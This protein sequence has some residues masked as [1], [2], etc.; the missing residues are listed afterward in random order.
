MANFI[1][2]YTDTGTGSGSTKPYPNTGADFK[3]V[4]VKPVSNI[5]SKTTT[6]KTTTTTTTK[7]TNPTTTQQVA[8]PTPV[9]SSGGGESSGGGGGGGGYEQPQYNYNNWNKYLE[10]MNSLINNQFNLEKDT[11]NKY[12]S[13]AGTNLQRTED[14]WNSAYNTNRAYLDQLANQNA[15]REQAINAAISD[16]Y[17][18]LIGNADEYYQNLIGTY[19]RSMGYVNQ[20]YEEGRSASEQARDEAINLAQ[21]LY[22]MGEQTQNRQT[23]KGLRSQYISYLKGMRNMNQQLAAQ[24]INGGASETALLN[25][26]N[27]YEGNRSDMYEANLAALGALRQQQMQS[28]SDAQQAYLNKVADLIA[29]RTQN[30]LGVENTRATGESNYAGM[31]SDAINTRSNQTLQ[32][33]QAF[34]NW[35]S[36]LVNQRSSNENTYATAIANLM[37]DK[38]AVEKAWAD[39]VATAAQNRTANYGS[40]AQTTAIDKLSEGG[41]NAKINT[42][43]SNR[44]TK[45]KKA[46][47]K[48]KAAKKSTTTKK[49]TKKSTKK[50]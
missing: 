33:Q 19:D 28:D 17:K 14:Q 15:Q 44:T 39:S 25:A 36:D 3:P 13:E 46:A 29:Q 42:K 31:K 21:A 43:T 40:S 2:M 26:L 32:A 34:Q 5:T 4:T 20:G 35:A 23:E 24:G 8:Q 22:E 12:K 1:P 27:G 37:N 11:A 18:Q 9:T 48:K 16:A 7:T 6:P 30:Q 45:E 47:E 41:K 38:N 50:K 49:S 10:M